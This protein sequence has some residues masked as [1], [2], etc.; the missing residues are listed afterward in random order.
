MLRVSGPA[1]TRIQG[2]LF[3]LKI[4]FM[5]FVPEIITLGIEMITKLDVAHRAPQLPRHCG[6]LCLRP[7]K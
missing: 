4:L 6:P 5:I 3:C 7:Y 2:L 1:V